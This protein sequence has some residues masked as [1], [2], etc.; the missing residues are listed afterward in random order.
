MKDLYR[1]FEKYGFVS[2]IILFVILFV[3]LIELFLPIEW[4]SQNYILRLVQLHIQYDAILE[5]TL[6]TVNFLDIFMLVLITLVSISLLSATL[7]SN[8]LL[9][10]FAVILPPVGIIMF[11]LTSEIGRT[12]MFVTVIC[13]SILFLRINDIPKNLPYLGLVSGILILIPDIGFMLGYYPIMGYIMGTGYVLLM[14]WYC[15][16]GIIMKKITA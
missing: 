9:A 3:G 15:Y 6:S 5:Q 7:K 10:W 1:Y 8:K 16:L 13:L 2:P 14:I 4:M 12:T 11:I